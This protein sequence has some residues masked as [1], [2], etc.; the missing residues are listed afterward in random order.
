MKSNSVKSD[1]KNATIGLLVILGVIALIVLW[2]VWWAYSGNCAWI[3]NYLSMPSH[4]T[5]KMMGWSAWEIYKFE[6]RISAM[7]A[8]DVCW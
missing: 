5:L 3:D 1:Q 2:F 6:L 7:M 4:T 8:L